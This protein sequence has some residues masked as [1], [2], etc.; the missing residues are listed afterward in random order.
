M[1]IL[2][3]PT[4]RPSRSIVIWDLVNPLIEKVEGAAGDSPE[5]TP[6][7]LC[8]ASVTCLYPRACMVEP[9]I[10]STVAGVSSRERPRRLAASEG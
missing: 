6:G 1:T 10:T 9:S 4:Q 7:R 2:A 5:T 8:T 3:G